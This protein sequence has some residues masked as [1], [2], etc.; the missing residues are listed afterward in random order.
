MLRR[1]NV[2]PDE[3]NDT[4]RITVASIKS[5]SPGRSRND[6]TS[7]NVQTAKQSV[8]QSPTRITY[9]Y[10]SALGSFLKERK[11][12][13]QHKLNGSTIATC[14]CSLAPHGE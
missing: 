8:L 1:N 6:R 3:K 5:K 13:I 7:E 2:V 10:A 14:L 9:K 11:K 12:K 4:F